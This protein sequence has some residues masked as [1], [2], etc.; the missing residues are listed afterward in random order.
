[1]M[2]LARPDAAAVPLAIAGGMLMKKFAV[3]A[4]VVLALLVLWAVFRVGGSEVRDAA[5]AGPVALEVAPSNAGGPVEAVEPNPNDAARVEV[6]VAP[7]PTVAPQLSGT[8]V[9]MPD[10]EPAV[11]IGVRV[12]QPERPDLGVPEYAVTDAQGRFHVDE[13]GAGDFEVGLD[14]VRETKRV[15]FAPGEKQVLQLGLQ[16]ASTVVGRVLDASG[17]AVAG[18]EVCV[19][20][21]SER[22]SR[23][24][25]RSAADGSYAIE[26]VPVGPR[27]FARASGHSPSGAYLLQSGDARYALDLWLGDDPGA[28]EG[29]VTD[30]AGDPMSGLPI[31]A[32]GASETITDPAGVRASV[33]T[34]ANVRADEH[35]AFV[36]RDLR[37]GRYEI[38]LHSL[39]R[40]KTTVVVDVRPGRTTR[41][42]VVLPALA[43]LHGRFTDKSG[44]P[45]AGA[46]VEVSTLDG[47]AAS[48]WILADADG[49]YDTGFVPSGHV[50]FSMRHDRGKLQ[51]ETDLAPGEDREWSPVLGAPEMIRGRVVDV[52]RRPLAGV[53]V[54]YGSRKATEV[55]TDSSGDFELAAQAGVRAYLTAWQGDVI[56][57][58]AYAWPGESEIELL[59]EVPSARIS[60]RVVDSAAAPAQGLVVFCGTDSVKPGADGRFESALLPSGSCAVSVSPY[61]VG[62][63][64]LVTVDLQ[65]GEARDL[66]DLVLPGRG[67]LVVALHPRGDV[68]PHRVEILA[69]RLGFPDQVVVSRGANRGG[70]WTVEGLPAGDYRVYL[71]GGGAALSEQRCAVRPGETT[72]VD[73]D[74]WFGSPVRVDVRDERIEEYGVEVRDSAGEVIGR[75]ERRSYGSAPA[76]RLRPGRYEILV[77]TTDGRSGSARLEVASEPRAEQVVRVDV[78]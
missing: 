44:A 54:S 45:C 38:D 12:S 72:L 20:S 48:S 78:R 73:V 67:T 46:W 2:P 32:R 53:P 41:A 63:C 33:R 31:A 10:R 61:G 11:G 6:A 37:P 34:A 71:S 68:D 50:K 64:H 66:G 55:K 23:C 17:A 74:A 14:R 40:T 18:A 29:R 47:P 35:G 69:Y 13:L 30:A 39:N 25:T 15:H 65:P 42:D 22:W 24:V 26:G 7:G 57:A 27:V 60:G 62:K 59:F 8:V 36:L 52:A 49:R 77:T 70:D 9:W 1:M 76:F 43:R 56:A 5:L 51:I 58:R 75:T 3:A 21:F 16:R 4:A 19:S 28:I